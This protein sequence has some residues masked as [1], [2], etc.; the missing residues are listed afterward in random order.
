MQSDDPALRYTIYDPFWEC[1][2]CRQT[3]NDAAK[4][5]DDIGCGLILAVPAEHVLDPPVCRYRKTGG[6]WKM[7]AVNRPV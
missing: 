3:F 2:Y 1:L 4:V 6:E 7:E 5:A